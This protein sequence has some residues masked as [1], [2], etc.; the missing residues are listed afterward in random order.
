MN[1]ADQITVTIRVGDAKYGN[2]MRVARQIS[3][4]EAEKIAIDK[5]LWQMRNEGIAY[6]DEDYRT[7]MTYWRDADGAPIEG[8]Q[9]LRW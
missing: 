5:M 9:R 2:T 6:T 1:D 4:H 3:T 7:I 8:W